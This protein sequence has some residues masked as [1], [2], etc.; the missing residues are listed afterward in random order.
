VTEIVN[1]VAHGSWQTTLAGVVA[2]LCLSGPEIGKTF[3][4]DPLTVTNWVAVLGALAVGA[5]GGAARDNN[6]RSEDVG[7][8]K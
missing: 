1:K 6:K 3:D 8:A 2:A 5:L 7:A 4:A